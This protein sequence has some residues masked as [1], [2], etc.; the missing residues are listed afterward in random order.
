METRL[1]S[2]RTRVTIVQFQFIAINSMN[3]ADLS[4]KAAKKNRQK[5]T[6]EGTGNHRIEKTNW[7]K[8]QRQVLPKSAQPA[9][10]RYYLREA[11]A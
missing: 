7:R 11:D 1:L 4:D 5:E 9:P 3:L 8:E 10:L 2:D 6:K